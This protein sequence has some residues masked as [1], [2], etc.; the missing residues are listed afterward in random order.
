M[1]K[2]LL[3]LL[4]LPMIGF[5]QNDN[6]L[7]LQD[8]VLRLQDDVNDIN[9]RMDIHHKRFYSGVRL[10]LLGVGVSIIGAVAPL[11]PLIYIG[12]AGVVAGNIIV[13]N[14][15]ESFKNNAEMNST[16]MNSTKMNSTVKDTIG[17]SE[18]EKRNIQLDD[19]WKRGE[20][21]KIEL[22][23]ERKKNRV[24]NRQ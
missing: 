8:D 9:Y 13:L 17:Y 15:H 20:I 4:C 2:I 19:L 21:T 22:K 14:S 10:S 7:K 1:K 24:S 11:V 18:F 5:G 6:I 3:I 23:K 12:A 16:K